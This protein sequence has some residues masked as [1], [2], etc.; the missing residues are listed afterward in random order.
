MIITTVCFWKNC[1]TLALVCALV[2]T[3]C[4][5]DKSAN[6]EDPTTF[7]EDG[8]LE[9]SIIRT[10]F[11]V[12]HVTA[13]NL[14]SLAFGLGY[15]FAEDNLCL[16]AD[17][18]VKYSSQ[19]SKYFGPDQVLGSG[20][21]LNL[22]NDF[23]YKALDIRAQAEAGFPLMSERLRAMLSGYTQGYNHYLEVTPVSQQ[24]PRC[25]GQPWLQ[26]ISE[27]DMVTF[28]VGIALLPGAGQFLAPL[29][30][31]APPG[32]SYL[33]ESV[34]EGAAAQVYQPERLDLRQVK[35]P[36]SKPKGLGSNGWALGM[37]KSE[38]QGG[39]LLANPHFP[40]TGNL[41]F[42]QFQ[43]TIPGAMDTMGASLAGMPGIV[44]IGFNREVAWT[45]TVSTAQHFI[46]Y[47]LSLDE[48]DTSGMTYLVDGQSKQIESR[49]LTIDVNVNGMNVPL[50][51]EVYYSDFG[52]MIV[53][54][55]QLGWGIDAS[56]G[57]FSAYSIKDVNEDNLDLMEF[58]MA[59]NLAGD[60]SQFQQAFQ[61]YDGVI[62]NNTMAVDR[63][64][65][66]FYIDD[67]TVPNLSDVA[68]AAL[69]TDPTLIAMREMAGFVILPGDS[70]VFDFEGPVP[71]QEAPKLARSDFVQ[72]SNDS[73]W[74][75]NPHQPLSGYSTLYGPV[76]YQQTLRSRMGQ[77]L[78]QDAAGEDN[79]FSLDE[80]EQVLINNRNYLGEEVQDDLLGLCDSL[81]NT[82]VTIGD[83]AV[84]VA[85]GC[86]ALYQWDGLMNLDSRGAHL[87]REFA[88]VFATNPQWLNSFDPA[89]PLSTPN[90]LATNQT[91]MEQFATAI[92]T[93][94]SAG[95][96]LDASLGEVQY[97]ERSL[98]DGTASGE[99]L[100]WAGANEIEG[101]F[102]IFSSNLNND[103][104][105]LPRHL[106]ASL[107][108]S[109]LSAEAAG[110]PITY[111]SSW[112]MV[113]EFLPTGPNARGLLSYSQ[114][115]NPASPYYD[116]QTKIYSEQPRLRPIWFDERDIQTHAQSSLQLEKRVR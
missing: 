77:R 111:G 43:G 8:F 33:P 28:A 60:M 73:Y 37:D 63:K 11:G 78:L 50:T 110:Y 14:E 101:G 113:V 71:Y 61:D 102:N 49:L 115:S 106:Y 92:A 22:I 103:G 81:E 40:H 95:L 86:Q 23:S 59:L 27:V 96:S 68:E 13:D 21:S 16:L 7:D 58:W 41:R 42:W 10:E 64:G 34:V 105:L 100:S 25:A 30:V 39:M 26:P 93:V 112:M 83:E 38:N 57:L 65:N 104:T 108:G 87:F 116:D 85:A 19:R 24:D 53:V 18:V 109:Q 31:A 17:Q 46:V 9:V 97:V 56:T 6:N 47:R 76:D 5:D 94:R 67:S 72:N 107:P 98:L 1:F 29:F 55:D 45:H 75:T 20:D 3:G 80:L 48:T 84:D 36:E 35:L 32:E 4:H 62:F 82:Q 15:A 79:L 52:P 99:K 88:Q 44:N 89:D 91:V 74:L 90:T 66:A 69:T 12:P 114:A 54:P 2:L 51:K 70:S